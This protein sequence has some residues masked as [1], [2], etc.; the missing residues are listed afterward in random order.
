MLKLDLMRLGDAKRFQEMCFRLARASFPHA[1]PM[2]FASWDR[3]SDIVAFHELDDS[4]GRTRGD[5]IWQCKFTK[6]LGSNTRRAIL[7]SLERFDETYETRPRSRPVHR[8]LAASKTRRATTTRRAPAI[9]RWTAKKWILCIPVE[10]TRVFHDW[11]RPHLAKRRIKWEI[12]DAVELQ[13]RL[14]KR[15]DIVDA[16]F[17]QAYAE[18]RRYFSTDELQLVRMT[19][20]TLCQWS[21]SDPKTLLVTRSGNVM[22]P[23]LVFDIVVRNIGEVDTIIT[24][25]EAEVAEALLELHGIPGDGLLFPQI[26]Y[27][28]SINGGV[29]GTY[30]EECE[31]PLIVRAKSLERFKVRLTHTGYS[32]RGPVRI[33]LRFGV[34]KKLPLPWWWVAT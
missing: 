26:T 7:E 30:A 29:P 13:L 16:Y 6:S 32:W 33:S 25:I 21:H 20:D 3:G 28:V 24:G 14:E 9:A 27:A 11:L 18:L 17:Y 22:S 15:P 10:A 31:P 2:A 5:T 34:D 4:A 19:L 23:D 12:W 8:A 1:K